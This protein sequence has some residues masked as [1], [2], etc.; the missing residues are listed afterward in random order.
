M[1]YYKINDFI[2]ML[3]SYLEVSSIL[4]YYKNIKEMFVRQCTWCQLFNTY[5]I[6]H[7][8]E[9]GYMYR[10]VPYRTVLY[11]KTWMWICDTFITCNNN[12]RV[13]CLLGR[14]TYILLC[15][16]D[17]MSAN[18]IDMTILTD[19]TVCVVWLYCV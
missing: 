14:Y 11:R 16:L 1:I 18:F 19:S 17:T 15:T 4:Y 3:I 10:T 6:A 12:K 8:T 7:E 5:F 9:C 13:C 2:S